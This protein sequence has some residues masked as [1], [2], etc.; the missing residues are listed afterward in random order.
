MTA[1]QRAVALAE[2]DDM[3][4]AVGED[5]HLDVA[6]GVDIFLD[7]HAGVGKGGARLALGGRERRIEFGVALDLAHALAAAAGHRLDQ[8]R[9]ANLIGLALEES[10]LLA[11]A[12]IAGHHRHAGLLHQRLGAVLQPH[13]A[14]RRRRRADEG[15][16]GNAAG[17]GEVGIFRQKA[18]AGMDAG[19]I[20]HLRGGDQSLTGKV[21]LRRRCRADLD[22]LVGE[23]D[24]QRVA[25]GL[26]IDRDHAQ[27]EPPGAAGDAA[28]DLAAIGDEDG[29]EHGDGS[30]GGRS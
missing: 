18:V 23:A 10:G 15:E 27:A 28:G 6:R 1:L 11:L 4:V 9:I 2:M 21:A 14:D 29:S 24:M 13:G 26:R 30:R 12:V 17:F 25:V 3:A 22:R 5:L 7:E 8:H 20:A 19:R 16:A